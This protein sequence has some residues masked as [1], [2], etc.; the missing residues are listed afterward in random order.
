LASFD[1]LAFGN[2]DLQGTVDGAG[3]QVT[4]RSASNGKA[5][6]IYSFDRAGAA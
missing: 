2:P 5:A 6:A 3:A 1:H 4:I